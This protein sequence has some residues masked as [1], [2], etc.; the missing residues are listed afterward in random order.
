M[1]NWTLQQ[2]ILALLSL[3]QPLQSFVCLLFSKFVR[4]LPFSSWNQESKAC[5]A[6]FLPLELECCPWVVVTK[7][8]IGA[9]EN[10]CLLKAFGGCTWWLIAIT[11]VPD[12]WHRRAIQINGFSASTLT[13]FFTFSRFTALHARQY[14]YCRNKCYVALLTKHRMTEVLQHGIYMQILHFV[15]LGLHQNASCRVLGTW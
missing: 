10:S 11:A 13:F 4:T 5:H 14:K 7:R 9:S 2:G 6:W 3:A 8:H 12:L 1:A 15:L